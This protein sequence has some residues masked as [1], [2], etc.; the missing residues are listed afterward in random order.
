P[1]RRQ[2]EPGAPCGVV[3]LAE[4]PRDDQRGEPPPPGGEG[5]AGA[6]APPARRR[7]EVMIAPSSTKVRAPP[8]GAI[9]RRSCANSARS[10]SDRSPPSGTWNLKVRTGSVRT[11]TSVKV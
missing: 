6:A 11:A 9:P 3:I 2:A 10:S 5:A 4:R 8:S 7:L 1:L